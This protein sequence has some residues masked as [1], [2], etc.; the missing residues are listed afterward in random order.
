MGNTVRK[1]ESFLFYDS[2][3]IAAHLQR[4]AGQG[5]FL[6]KITPFFWRYRRGEPESRIYAITYF[7]EA[8]DFNPGPTEHQQTYLDY[9]A[10]AG[11]ELAA[12]WAQMQIF[13]TAQPQPIP[14]ET[15]E[16]VKLEGIHRSMKKN[17]LPGSIV[18][19]ALS[20]L[21]L[22]MQLSTL[23]GQ[24]SR[25]FS[26]SLSLSVLLVW[27][28][29]LA[30]QSAVVAGY[31]VWYHRS[32]R[33]VAEGGHCAGTAVQRR[34]NRLLS[35]LLFLALLP[36]V[37]AMA[38]QRSSWFGL[39]YVVGIL[40]VLALTFWLR[41]TLKRM[42][43][44]RTV[45][46]TV[47]LVTCAV[48]SFAMMGGLVWATLRG[49]RSGAWKETPPETYIV[50]NGG[51][52]WTWDIYHDELPLTV[53]ELIPGAQGRYSTEWDEAHSV[54]ARKAEGSQNS[55]PD[56]SAAP[57]DLNYQIVTSPFSAV[58]SLCLREYLTRY[59]DRMEPDA[60]QFRTVEQ[61]LWQAE[62]VY[63]LFFGEEAAGQYLV[64]RGDGFLWLRFDAP[65]T[66]E[67]ITVAAERLTW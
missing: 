53:E 25:Y 57:P 63:Q 43:V 58:R 23:L 55:V 64:C 54:F 50:E 61:P 20:V 39:L 66:E 10:D 9:C 3:G 24:P 47:N 49:I 67:Q 11:W 4:R 62:T 38:A 30:F 52:S 12:E 36:C 40:G 8:S 14:I 59:E 31:G 45:N 51:S 16:A 46:L 18:L 27:L 32:R 2:E 21:Q 7:S 26:N 44:T 19:V 5:L 42:R 28:A 37:W 1:Y 15:E 29:L 22:A 13:S 17:F 41:E 60:P 34:I 48:L 56:G 35:P 33:S 65:L 6:E